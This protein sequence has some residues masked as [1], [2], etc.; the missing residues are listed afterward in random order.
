[1]KDI[2]DFITEANINTK[3]TFD[4]QNDVYNVLAELAYEYNKKNKDHLFD[5][6]AME[7]ALEF[8]MDKFYEEDERDDD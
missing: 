4:L 1:M 8:F 6:D 3:V 5:K 2:K 7:D